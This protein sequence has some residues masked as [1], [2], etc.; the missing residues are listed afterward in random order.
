[1]MW[2]EEEDV[3]V[4]VP[5]SERW[6]VAAHGLAYRSENV[7]EVFVVVG[8][9]DVPGRTGPWGSMGSWDDVTCP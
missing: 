9:R 8:R 4:F 5:E 3:D 6:A 7:A 1:M 2:E